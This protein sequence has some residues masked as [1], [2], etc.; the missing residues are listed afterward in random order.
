MI[1]A[2]TET[3]SWACDPSVLT[4]V[5]VYSLEYNPWKLSIDAEYF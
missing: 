1:M 4:K 3:W 5:I 2:A